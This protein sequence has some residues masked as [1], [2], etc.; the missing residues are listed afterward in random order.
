M[1]RATAAAASAPHTCCSV[2]GVSV[3][4]LPACSATAAACG[5]S[6]SSTL[7][8]AACKRFEGSEVWQEGML[9]AVTL[10]VQM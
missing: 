5:T 1:G 8:A 4:P 9:A 2:S 6:G 3:P 7:R 10:G